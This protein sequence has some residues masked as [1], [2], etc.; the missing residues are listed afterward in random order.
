MKANVFS[1]LMLLLLT[2]ISVKAT[3]I[4]PSLAIGDDWV[5]GSD[6]PGNGEYWNLQIVNSHTDFTDADE[7]CI[8]AKVENIDD[9]HRWKIDVVDIMLGGAIIQSNESAW[10]DVGA[11]W[12][13]STIYPKFIL[14]IGNYRAE[15]YLDTGN[16]YVLIAS[17]DF[18]VSTGV[19][20]HQSYLAVGESWQHGGGGDNSSP[21]YWDLQI[22][23]PHQYFLVGQSV[24]ALAKVQDVHQRH[25][26]RV[27]L[28]CQDV[29]R[30]SVKSAWHDVGTG[31]TYSSIYPIFKNLPVEEY[32][33]RAYI[34]FDSGEFS[35]GRVKFAVVT[36]LPKSPTDFLP[37]IYKLLL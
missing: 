23:N 9:N 1:I 5:Y 17:L 35:V 16:G 21:E 11:G 33:I 19:L 32:E 34:L 10:H 7:I 36:E 27:D 25:A 24:V 15:A 4:N 20:F 31:W 37:A 12:G 6:N 18:V 3:Y 30:E 2:P 29:L 13:Y 22:M 28:Y 8:L 14:P 26:W